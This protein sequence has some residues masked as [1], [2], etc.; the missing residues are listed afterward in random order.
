[1]TEE[2]RNPGGLE[3]EA[4]H[5]AYGA[6]ISA[7]GL[8]LTIGALTKRIVSQSLHHLGD[9][10]EGQLH[11]VSFENPMGILNKRGVVAELRLEISDSQHRGNRCPEQ[12]L[13]KARYGALQRIL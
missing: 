12:D 1:M 13:L 5:I 4:F 2:L 6:K 8:L 10:K 7:V 9:E 11:R 3:D